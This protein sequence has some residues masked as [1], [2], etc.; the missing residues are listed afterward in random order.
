VAAFFL[1]PQT[2]TKF[3]DFFV[4][5]AACPCGR[6]AA[7]FLSP[8]TFTKFGDFFYIRHPEFLDCFFVSLK[9]YFFFA[10]SRKKKSIPLLHK[11]VVAG[12]VFLLAVI[13]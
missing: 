4:T 3:G 12:A 5:G 10:K 6:T 2:F 13:E 7:F 8:Q 9:P 11:T 1:S